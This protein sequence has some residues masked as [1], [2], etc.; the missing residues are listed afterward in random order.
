MDLEACLASIRDLSDLPRLVTAL[1]HEPLWEA[2]APEG[3]QQDKNRRF[4][5]QVVGQTGSLPWFA[6]E[7]P[8]PVRTATVLAG[9]LKRRGRVSLVLALDSSLRR[10]AI[11]V[12]FE[13]TPHFELDLMHPDQEAFVLLGKLAGKPAGGTMAFAALAADALSTEPVSRRFFREFHT[14]LDRVSAALAGPTQPED[15]HALALLQLTRVLFLYFIQS[16]GW[17]GARER[18]LAEEVDRC[19]A[20][21]RQIHRDL[22]RPLFFGTLNRPA[23]S[24]SRTARAFGA[25][26]FLNGGLFEPHQLERRFH[27]DIPNDIWCN[28]FDRLFER[29]HFTLSERDRSGVAPDM[30]GRV[31]EGVMAPE[32]RHASGTFYTP[33]SLVHELLDAALVGL[34]AQRTGCACRKAEQL[35]RTRHP[36]A[37]QVCHTLTLLDP[38]V[39]SGAF[40]LGALERLASIEPDERSRSAR[41]REV[42]RRNLFGVDQ[43]GTAVRLTELRLWLAVI[44]DDPAEN[45]DAVSPLPNLDCLIRQGDSLFDPLGWT[46]GSRQTTRDSLELADLRRQAVT[47]A[48]S[49]KRALIRQLRAAEAR[50]LDHSLGLAEERHRS[51][52]AACLG[53][54][55]AND[56][57]GRQRGLDRQCRATLLSLRGGLRQ[58]RQ[59]RRNLARDGEVP[60]FHYQSHFADVFARGGF[61]IVIGNPPWLRSELLAPA[62]RNRLRGRYRWWRSSGRCYGNGPDLAVA[63]LERGLELT[64]PAGVVAMLLPA[65]VTSAG[66]GAAARH[67]LASTTTLHAI[68]DLTGSPLAQFEA[69]VYPLAVITGKAAPSESHRIRTTF[70]AETPAHVLQIGL[71]GGGPWILVRDRVKDAIAELEK[72]Q[73]ALGASVSCHLGLK[74]G[75]NRVFLNPPIHLEDEV[76]RW[77]IRG[78]DLSP[79]RWRRRSRLLWTHDDGGNPRREL[80]PKAAAYLKACHSELRARRDFKGGIPWAVFRARPAVAHYRVVWADLAR[81]LVAAALSKPRD[82]AYIPLNSCYV[83]PVRSSVEGERLAAWLNSTWLRALARIGAVPAAS[84]FARFNSQVVARLPL[85]VSVL[86]DPRLSRITG[87]GRSGRAVQEELDDIAAEHLGLSPS[88]QSALRSVL[89]GTAHYRR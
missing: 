59:A 43:N 84:G 18:F 22:L 81:R 8:D 14:T 41:K 24:R 49:D 15:R 40:L 80:P 77:A 19:L 25:I 47:A 11:A 79:F 61:D 30:L 27:A 82:R 53:Y 78:R 87:E 23:A 66:Y 12:A 46:V 7:C 2:A 21:G 89:A 70:S 65:K 74:T 29:F 4:E 26:P 75:A 88:S 63:F 36:G 64:A 55:R 60:W 1:G 6:T 72:T 20:G 44:A 33:A 5:V 9:R 3:W 35:L 51:E 76:L 67:G 56:L 16:K 85:P 58:V 71:R 57:F 10:L 45:L 17:L 39:G 37:V 28:A 38:A 32:T 83:A 86:T 52:I 73:P 42:L 50:V 62:L 31:F 34:I 54:A 69:T 13:K 48:G 68:V